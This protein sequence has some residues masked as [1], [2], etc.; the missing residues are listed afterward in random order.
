MCAR[1][2]LGSRLPRTSALR[3]LRHCKSFLWEPLYVLL[4][5]IFGISDLWE[6]QVVPVWL[7]AAKGLIFLGIIA[8][9]VPIVM[10]LYPGKKL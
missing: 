7:V 9:R 2:L 8:V 5:V 3:F 10:R 1:Q 4:F 6:S